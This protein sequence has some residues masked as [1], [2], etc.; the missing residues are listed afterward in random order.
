MVSKNDTKESNPSVVPERV[1]VT[2]E[3]TIWEDIMPDAVKKLLDAV[4]VGDT[5]TGG[6]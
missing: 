5:D 1:I 6:E 4:V 3:D 2:P